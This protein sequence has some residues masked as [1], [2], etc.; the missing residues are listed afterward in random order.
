MKTR[1][2]TPQT[3]AEKVQAAGSGAQPLLTTALGGDKQGPAAWGGMRV[4]VRWSQASL[5]IVAV[6]GSLFALKAAPSLLAPPEPPPIPADVGLPRI[7][8]EASATRAGANTSKP[9]RPRRSAPQR[10]PKPK[11]KRSQQSAAPKRPKPNPGLRRQ[12]KAPKAPSQPPP[13]QSPVPEPPPEPT[14]S[15]VPSP[16]VVSPAPTPEPAP[17]T[18][19]PN[20]GS[21]EFAP[22]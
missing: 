18:P 20:D 11:H 21:M 14:P 5:L 19:A 10:R 12:Q 17:V 7:T 3:A 6:V 9:K 15:Y 16:E 13:P 1:P 2:L 4:R 22:H 8:P